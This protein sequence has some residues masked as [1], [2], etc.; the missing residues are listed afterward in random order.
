[1]VSLRTKKRMTMSHD[2]RQLD[3]FYRCMVCGNWWDY[4][5][6]VGGCAGAPDVCPDNDGLQHHFGVDGHCHMCGRVDRG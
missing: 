4:P 5:R 3:D 2:L 6:P 1:M